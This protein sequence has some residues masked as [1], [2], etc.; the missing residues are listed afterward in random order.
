MSK[1][2]DTRLLAL[3]SDTFKTFEEL[4]ENEKVLKA[5]LDTLPTR[6]TNAVAQL[7]Q[8]DSVLATAHQG[9]GNDQNFMRKVVEQ[10]YK[11]MGTRSKAPWSP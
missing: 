4:A 8:H 11:G 2:L 5:T 6:I 3:R 10:A 1:D 9:P 7:T